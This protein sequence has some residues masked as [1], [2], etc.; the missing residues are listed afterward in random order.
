VGGGELHLELTIVGSGTAVPYKGRGAPGYLLRVSGELMAL[1]IGPGTVH[2][3]PEAGLSC[4]DVAEVYISHLHPD[5]VSDLVTLLFALRN[6]HLDRVKPLHIIGPVGLK[7]Y[8]RGLQGLYGYWVEEEGYNLVVKEIDEE[9]NEREYRTVISRRVRHTA[10]SLGYRIE[11]PNGK[12]AVYSGDTDYCE[13]LI[14]LGQGAQ[15]LILECSVPEEERIE[16]H[17]TP[18]LA[19]KIAEECRAE[20]LVLT[21]FYPMFDAIDIEERVRKV[22]GGEVVLAEDM[23]RIPI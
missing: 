13:G 6:Q 17:L 10:S 14:E 21:H 1:D 12:V 16:G 7:D 18:T 19:G 9:T 23:M 15:V 22:F 5:H 11:S 2:R 20:K 3:W 8:Y 4:L